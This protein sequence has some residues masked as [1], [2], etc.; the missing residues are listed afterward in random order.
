MPK[1]AVYRAAE[2][3]LTHTKTLT[4]AH[5]CITLTLLLYHNGL[6]PAIQ[7]LSESERVSLSANL[8]SS[9]CSEPM[10][11]ENFH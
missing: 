1:K 11:N 5:A 6:R 9:G 3:S 4:Q 7:H 8:Y 2:S 10:D